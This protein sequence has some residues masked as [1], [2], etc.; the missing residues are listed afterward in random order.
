MNTISLTEKTGNIAGMPRRLSAYMIDYLL[1]LITIAAIHAGIYFY[2]LNPIL[3]G[4][5]SVTG[6]NMHLWVFFS[7]T[8]PILL[9]FWL[10]FHRGETPGM[11]LLGLQVR[12]RDRTMLSAWQALGRAVVLLIPFEINHVIWFYP[13]PAWLDKP[14]DFRMA[15]L[16]V[17]ALL[18]I[19]LVVPLLNTKR[20]SVH[21]FVAGS[22]VV[23]V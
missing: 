16:I 1:M 10:F 17:Y 7:A 14:P 12:K 8:L 11:R 2:G 9:Y 3:N 15:G 23:R 6:L 4:A 13:Q 19:Y 21:D 20:Q 18:A 5:L 22:I